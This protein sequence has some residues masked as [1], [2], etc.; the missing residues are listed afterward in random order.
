MHHCLHVTEIVDLIAQYSE[1]PLPG[2]HQCPS[3]ALSQTCKAFYEPAL[4]IH[5]K[6]L[7]TLRPFMA[8]FPEDVCAPDEKGT[9]VSLFNTSSR[10]SC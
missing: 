3:V 10:E 5:W 7:E 8:C 9:Y 6:A 4:N 2:S 1:M